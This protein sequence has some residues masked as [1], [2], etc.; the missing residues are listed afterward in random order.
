MSTPLLRCALLLL[1]SLDVTSGFVLFG[2]GTRQRKIAA[3]TIKCQEEG[4]PA[5]SRSVDDYG[6][7]GNGGRWPERQVSPQADQG[8]SDRG[9]YAGGGGYQQREGGYGGGGGGGYQQREGGYGRQGGGGGGY[10]SEGGYGRQGGGGGG[11]RSEGGYDRGGGGGVSGGGGGYDRGGGGGGGGG[12]QRDRPP[13]QMQQSFERGPRA[14][15]SSGPQAVKPGDWTCPACSA[16]VFASKS[17]CFKCGAPNP[18]PEARRRA[19]QNR[20]S[21][22]PPPWH[23]DSAGRTKSWKWQ[24]LE[25]GDDFDDNLPDDE[26]SF[27]A[28]F[29]EAMS[30]GIDF[31]KYA[32]IPVKIDL[33]PSLSPEAAEAASAVTQF[34]GLKCGRLLLRNLRFAGF[35]V[36]TPVQAHSVPL[37]MQSAD[38]ISVAQTGSGKTLAFML[39]ILY[40]ILAA[41]SAPHRG[42]RNEPVAV[43]AVVLAPTR[44]LASQIHEESKK[45]AYRTG[46]RV[47]V[48]YGGTPFGSQMRE[49]ERGCDILIATPGRLNDMI[50]RD[51][52]TC[53]DVQFLVLD[54]ADRM[55][56]M[57]FEPQIRDIVEGSGMPSS[58]PGGRQT[59]MF[60]ATWPAGRFNNVRQIADSFLVNPAMLTVGRV[61]G[62]SESVTQKVAYVEGRRKTAAAIELL[63]EVWPGHRPDPDH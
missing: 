10:R 33:P 23:P 8:R 27:R 38:V 31:A 13:R 40:R 42:G 22:G 32:D 30:S 17:R 36:P 47:C 41:G 16:N 18:D 62:A 25:G 14:P 58:G 45:F 11:Y 34:S 51:R 39:P 29:G 56:D 46:L 9:G 20:G 48:A 3:S 15:R 52:V 59:M 19:A 26:Q 57:G 60:S 50:Q 7:R 5:S 63:R 6:A 1:G 49:L 35:E 21:R 24:G 43:R 44:E 53:R 2:H 55:L 54:E 61:G 12:Y 4:A 37:A 28:Q